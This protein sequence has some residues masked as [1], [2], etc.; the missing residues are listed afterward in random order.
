MCN[1]TKRN[2][3]KHPTLHLHNY[4]NDESTT[5]KNVSSWRDPMGSRWVSEIGMEWE[6]EL[7]TNNDD[8][9]SNL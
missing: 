6:S 9:N 3:I 8:N 4:D 2:S 1:T 5:A 7:S